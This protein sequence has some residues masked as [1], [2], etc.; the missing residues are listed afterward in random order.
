MKKFAIVLAGLLVFA[1]ATDAQ[2]RHP[3]RQQQR[4]QQNLQRDIRH[5][6]TT[7]PMKN[8]RP[9]P[10]YF[11]GVDVNVGNFRLRIGGDRPVYRPYYQPRPFWHLHR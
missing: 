5:P 8:Y 1:A 7:R 4:W 3:Q 11:K 10:H 9:R 6:A 2:A